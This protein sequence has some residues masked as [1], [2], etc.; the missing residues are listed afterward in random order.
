MSSSKLSSW[1]DNLQTRVTELS[2]QALIV[3]AVLIVCLLV[4]LA[5]PYIWFIL[6]LAVVVLFFVMICVHP[7]IAIALFC[8]M[9]LVYVL[10]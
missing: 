5:L 10:F 9:A 8:A 2:S 3:V 7:P 1:V 6:K 4:V